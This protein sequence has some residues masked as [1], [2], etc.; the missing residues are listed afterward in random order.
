MQGEGEYQNGERNLG[1]LTIRLCSFENCP[2]EIKFFSLCLRPCFKSG[3]IRCW[4]WG[5]DALKTGY[6]DEAIQN[7]SPG[8]EEWPGGVPHNNASY[9]TSTVCN[10]ILPVP[11]FTWCRQLVPGAAIITPSPLFL[12]AG[13]K[14]NSP[15]FIDRS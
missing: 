4:S 6:P 13:N 8:R 5:G 9:K 3:Q 11:S 2:W 14:T 1:D 12:T 7:G 10:A 15:I